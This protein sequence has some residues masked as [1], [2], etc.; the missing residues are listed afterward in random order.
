VI[1]APQHPLNDQDQTQRLSANFHRRNMSDV[2]IPDSPEL[3][4]RDASARRRN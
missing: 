4:K 2:E 1:H 3:H